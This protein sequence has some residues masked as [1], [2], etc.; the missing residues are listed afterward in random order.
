[1]CSIISFRLDLI[2]L[3]S[4]RILVQPKDSNI[5]F[6]VETLNM[7]YELPVQIH[8]LGVKIHEL[9]VQIHQ[10]QVKIYALGD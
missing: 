5:C 1:M 9:Q 8:E 3:E 4:L 10:L 2:H 6:L 7:S